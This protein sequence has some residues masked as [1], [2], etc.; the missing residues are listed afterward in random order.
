MR[1]H[2]RSNFRGNCELIT[3]FSR[4]FMLTSKRA[5]WE[6]ISTQW[7]HSHLPFFL[8]SLETTSFWCFSGNSCITETWETCWRDSL[9]CSQLYSTLPNL[10]LEVLIPINKRRSSWPKRGF[11]FETKFDGFVRVESMLNE[12]LFEDHNLFSKLPLGLWFV[13]IFESVYVGHWD[14]LWIVRNSSR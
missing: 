7:R 12:G 9:H 5:L 4:V 6:C 13:G 14:F 2:G 1:N 11:S 10:W 8:H 3:F